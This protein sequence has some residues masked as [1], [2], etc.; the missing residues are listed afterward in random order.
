ME[1]YSKIWLATDHHFGHNN[2]IK[3][4]DENGVPYRNFV[5]IEEHDKHLIE[6]HNDFVG[7]DDTVIFGGDLGMDKKYLESIFLKL[8]GKKKLIL[9]NHDNFSMT[10]YD[11]HFSRIRAWYMFGEK[12]VPHVIFSHFPLMPESFH[13]NK[14]WLNVHGHV[15]SNSV[16]GQ[17]SKNYLN[18]CPEEW[19]YAP[20]QVSELLLI[21]KNRKQAG[22]I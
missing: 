21:A 18:L 15:H 1:D 13:P 3:F 8:K 2:I 7:H 6:Q 16:T 5:S 20:T 22:L 10:F 14:P 19:S 17:R 4:A 12:D 11:K 9:G